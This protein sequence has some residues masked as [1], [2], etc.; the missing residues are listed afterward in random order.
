MAYFLSSIKPV[1]TVPILER[2]VMELGGDGLPLLS[3]SLC[4]A[5]AGSVGPS[6]TLELLALEWTEMGGVSGPSGD[7]LGCCC[8]GKA[9]GLSD[10]GEAAE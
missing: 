1:L 5:V 6:A 4:M 8:G 9:L 3:G 2:P 10:E 7:G